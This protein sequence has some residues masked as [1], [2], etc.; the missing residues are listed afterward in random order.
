MSI[1]AA[2]A[3]S[4][5]RGRGRHISALVDKMIYSYFSLRKILQVRIL[6]FVGSANLCTYERGACC[7]LASNR[8]GCLAATQAYVEEYPMLADLHEPLLNLHRRY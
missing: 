8:G 6:I 2:A 1:V 4:C 7:N 5:S 3:G